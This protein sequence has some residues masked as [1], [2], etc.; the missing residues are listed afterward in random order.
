MHDIAFI[1]YDNMTKSTTIENQND[2]EIGSNAVSMYFINLFDF[3]LLHTNATDVLKNQIRVNK[4]TIKITRSQISIVL[5]IFFVLK[6]LTYCHGKQLQAKMII[7]FFL[8]AWYF[9]QNSNIVP[10]L[11]MI[12]SHSN[13]FTIRFRNYCQSIVRYEPH[14]N[15]NILRKT[16]HRHSKPWHSS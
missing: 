11:K 14:I 15:E 3:I 6:T 4:F 12:Y 13:Y 10:K 2:M 1:N 8:I 16:Y 5:F 7:C 9:D